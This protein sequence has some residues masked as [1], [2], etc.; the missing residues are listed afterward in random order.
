MDADALW[1]V[2]TGQAEIR[3]EIVDEPRQGEALVR[4]LYSAISRG[5]E[6][7]VFAGRVP[8]SEFSRMRAPFMGGAFPFPVK[9]G[10]ATVGRVERGPAEWLGRNVF[11][12]HPHQSVFTLP[13]EAIV[14]A[15][16]DVPPARVA[17]AANME[18][19][20]NAVWDAAPAP[21]DQ[22]AV[23]G[24]GVVG[25]L[26]A[27][28]CGRLP[29]AK[30][31]LVDI[32]PSRALLARALGVGFAAPGQAPG[33]C[34]LVVH[35]SGTGAGLATAIDLAGDEARVLE[36]SWYGAGEVAVP[37]GGAFHSRRLQLISSQVGRVAPSHRPRWTHQRR[38]AAA[39]DLLADS[40]LDAL[41]APAVGFHELPARLPEILKPASGALCPLVVY[42]S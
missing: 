37:L 1:Y 25:S 22:I 40:R 12:L 36:L 23:V 34:D 16:D 15:P 28:L 14:L 13:V 8:E 35:A 18:T 5:T 27:W 42:P 41:L 7:L 4:A 29:G 9:Y 10:Y 38:L 3:R 39:L 26:V 19:A 31:T 2:G 33:D 20:L 11:A 30:V 32:E 24:G 17:L 6:R 21:A